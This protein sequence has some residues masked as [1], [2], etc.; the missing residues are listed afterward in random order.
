MQPPTRAAICEAA[1][2]PF[3]PEYIVAQQACW[4]PVT[5]NGLSLMGPVPGAR[6]AFVAAGHGVWGILNAPATGEAMAEFVREGA[7]RIIDLRPFD[8]ARLP[9][10][11]RA[12]AGP[13]SVAAWRAL[14]RHG[15]E[16]ERT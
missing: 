14:G 15:P 13:G 3:A 6:G 4:R 7:A 2:P 12:R 10:L 1:S 11:R 8:P 9:P 5:R 16:V